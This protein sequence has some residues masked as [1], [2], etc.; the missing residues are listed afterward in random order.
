[1][2]ISTISPH[3]YNP[4]N[5][6]KEHDWLIWIYLVS[7]WSKRER[8]S[9]LWRQKIREQSWC[10]LW[11]IIWAAINYSLDI[12]HWDTKLFHQPCKIFVLDN[13]AALKYFW[14]IICQQFLVIMWLTAK[15]HKQFCK[16]VI[17]LLSSSTI[18]KHKYKKVL[19]KTNSKEN[20]IYTSL[21]TNNLLCAA[22]TQEE[23]E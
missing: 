16:K 14:I 15:I 4:V 9:S 6:I 2:S 22:S 10:R 1:M 12:S 21:C 13:L 17:K 23:L 7:Y 20:K 11:G 5:W 3:R 19:M 18:K 8:Q